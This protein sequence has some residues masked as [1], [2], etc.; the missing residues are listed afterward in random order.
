MSKSEDKRI[1][2]VLKYNTH[3]KYIGEFIPQKLAD[4][5]A[6]LASS[7]KWD[8]QLQYEYVHIGNINGTVICDSLWRQ[9]SYNPVRF[10]TVSPFM[11]DGKNNIY[12][13]CKSYDG[14]N[15]TVNEV[16]DLLSKFLYLNRNRKTGA[17]HD[18][19]ATVNGN[20]EIHMKYNS[21]FDDNYHKLAKLRKCIKIIAKQNVADFDAGGEYKLGI[22]SVLGY[23]PINGYQM[24]IF[25][26]L[27]LN[28][29][30]SDIEKA[31]AERDRCRAQIASQQDWIDRN[32]G[33][34]SPAEIRETEQ[35]IE[36]DRQRYVQLSDK[37]SNLQIELKNFF[38][39]KMRQNDCK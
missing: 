6:K 37:I 20:L 18:T 15:A 16:R 26:G 21:H 5:C 28:K 9:M 14:D 4:A 36:Q 24:T 27:E 19:I 30:K 35:E 8:N 22:M 12:K 32:I 7:Q 17:W 34:E 38:Y 29:L 39:N 33:V 2:S 1:K 31:R 25:D 3:R 10:G 11:F 13:F 23:G